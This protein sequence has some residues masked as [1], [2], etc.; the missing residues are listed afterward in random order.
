HLGAWPAWS[1]AAWEPKAL[2]SVVAIGFPVA[3]QV[4]TE[5]WAFNAATL[6]A[7][8]LGTVTA[9]AH[10]VVLSM[11]S[12]SFMA[13]LGIAVGTTT[14]VGNLIGAGHHAGAQRA[15]RL[16]MLMGAGV[17]TISAV[18]FVVFRESLPLLYLSDPAVVALAASILPI[19]AAFQIFDGTQAV[20]CGVLRGMGRTRPAAGFNV[21]GYWVLGLPLGYWFGIRQGSLAGLWWGLA[22]GLAVV[23]FLLI[24]WIQRNG[25]AAMAPKD[26]R[27]AS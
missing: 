26:G 24:F 4:G 10:G 19:A 13:A 1:R 16:A 11:A 17:M 6:L 15:A 2:W 9:A 12:I 7:G 23:A 5:M 20:G 8:S 27:H 21:I 14:R 25:P 22:L 18:G 3:I